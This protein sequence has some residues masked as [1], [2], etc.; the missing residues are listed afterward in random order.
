MKRIVVDNGDEVVVVG[1]PVIDNID[2]RY[3]DIPDV[4]TV[5]PIIPVAVVDLS[6]SKRNPCHIGG[7]PNPAH[8]SGTPVN[9]APDGR[10]PEPSHGGD[11]IP[12]AVMIGSPA[13]G[14][15]RYPHIIS[16][17]PRPPTNSVR[18]PIRSN[19]TGR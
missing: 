3:V 12:S 4:D 16:A 19:D 6:R 7:S 8:K 10:D 9:C 1:M 18:R 15:I 11:K 5:G 14:F 13:P 2:I 17:N